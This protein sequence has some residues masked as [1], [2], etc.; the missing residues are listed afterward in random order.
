M[1]LHNDRQI[2]HHAKNTSAG[3]LVCPHCQTSFP[4][5]WRRYLLSPLGNHRCPQ[6]KQVSQL[7]DNSRWLWPIRIAGIMIYVILSINV[8]S[9]TFNDSGVVGTLIPARLFVLFVSVVVGLL[10]DKWVEGHVR[11]LKIRS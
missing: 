3:Q 11:H 7:K 9:Y 1:T 6:C 5:T 2:S 4:L 8:F 10:I